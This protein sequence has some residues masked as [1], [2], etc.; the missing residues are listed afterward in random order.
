MKNN[1]LILLK[2]WLLLFFV[3]LIFRIFIYFFGEQRLY[4]LIL[5]PI[6]FNGYYVI[7]N[8]IK[9]SDITLYKIKNDQVK[10]NGFVAFVWL[11]FCTFVLVFWIV[12]K[13]NRSNDFCT[14]MEF[15]NICSDY[16]LVCNVSFNLFSAVFTVYLV[17]CIVKNKVK[18]MTSLL[19]E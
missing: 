5:C 19:R 1:L 7:K 13:W 4:M 16:F 2:V 9:R 3:Y 6:L 12:V 15:G 14:S 11:V 10:N 18:K 8:G 17:L